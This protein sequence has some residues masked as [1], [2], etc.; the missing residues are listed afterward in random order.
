MV[1]GL[2]VRGRHFRFPRPHC[3]VLPPATNCSSPCHNCD[4]ASASNGPGATHQ[5]ENSLQ[6]V[7]FG[8]TATRL[9]DLAEPVA[10]SIEATASTS[11]VAAFIRSLEH[12][13][14]RP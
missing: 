9:L 10:S 6:I 3:R 7:T 4:R 12:M 2:R 1:A 8:E 11:C 13:S 5:I 14:I